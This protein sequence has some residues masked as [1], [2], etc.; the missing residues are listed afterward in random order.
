VKALLTSPKY[1]PQLHHEYDLQ[2]Y[3]NVEKAY[4][5]D[6]FAKVKIMNLLLVTTRKSS[7][8]PQYRVNLFIIF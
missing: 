7:F 8:F 1:L 2:N 5:Q 6:C 3:N 4:Y